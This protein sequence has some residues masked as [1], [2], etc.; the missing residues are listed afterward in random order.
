[1]REDRE[2][3]P[4]SVPRAQTT[5]LQQAESCC[6]V[7]SKSLPVV[8]NHV[9]AIRHQFTE[10]MELG[11]INRVGVAEALAQQVHEFIKARDFSS[12]QR[13]ERFCRVASPGGRRRGLL[14]TASLLRS[15]LSYMLR[16]SRN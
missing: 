16:P 7:R 8:G 2:P 13:R 11:G 15:G 5:G 6:A 10:A 1:V 4:L 14:V 9:G 12:S 3:S